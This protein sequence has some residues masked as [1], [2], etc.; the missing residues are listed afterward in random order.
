MNK[1]RI[2]NRGEPGKEPNADT[3]RAHKNEPEL[4]TKSVIAKDTGVNPVTVL[5]Y[6]EQKLIK[7]KVTRDSG[8]QYFDRQ[9]TVSKINLIRDLNKF[10]LKLDEIVQLFKE[11]EK[12]H[13]EVEK[14]KETIPH[15]KFLTL[16]DFARIE[17]G[18]EIRLSW[19]T[20]EPKERLVVNRRLIFEDFENF[21]R[22]LKPKYERYIAKKHI[23]NKGDILIPLRGGTRFGTKILI[24]DSEL[25]GA[26][27]D[28]SVAKLIYTDRVVSP[29]FLKLYLEYT[30]LGRRQLEMLK[31]GRFIL[32]IHPSELMKLEIPLLTEGEEA[33]VQALYKQK[34]LAINKYKSEISELEKGLKKGMDE[35]LK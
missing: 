17:V 12:Q 15:R 13:Q 5:Y 16:G 6:V 35:L 21:F 4:V 14:E 33:K 23:I 10:G 22:Y 26:I 2:L 11:K 8:Y 3:D 19:L 32:L 7:P 34:F 27:Y 31:H 20:P 28:R 1:R 9:E 30:H 25:E 18:P 24:A 29:E